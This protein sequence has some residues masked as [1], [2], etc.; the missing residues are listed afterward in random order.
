MPKHSESNGELLYV[1]LQP[2][3]GLAAWQSFLDPYRAERTDLFLLMW[4]TQLIID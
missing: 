1:W 3:Q 2:C 4:L